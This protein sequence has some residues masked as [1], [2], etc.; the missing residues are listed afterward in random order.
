ME[1]EEVEVIVMHP[2]WEEFVSFVQELRASGVP[3]ERII[4]EINA[5]LEFMELGKGCNAKVS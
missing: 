5:R 4:M 1:P 2:G 3:K